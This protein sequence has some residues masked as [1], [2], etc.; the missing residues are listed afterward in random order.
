MKRASTLAAGLAAVALAASACGGSASPRAGSGNGN[1]SVATIKARTLPKLGTV[2]VNGKGY[3]LYMFPPDHQDG[4]TCT[5]ACAGSWPPVTVPKGKTPKTGPKIQ[6]SLI[7]SVP[8][9]NPE[10]GQVVTYNDWPLYTYAA[11]THPGEATG[12]ALDVN[13]GLWY[14]MRP[15]GAIVKTNPNGTR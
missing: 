13:G 12:Q 11:D 1:G 10:G 5:G 6:Q 2:L 7:G 9:P 8:N 3:T 4:V 15:S 14:V